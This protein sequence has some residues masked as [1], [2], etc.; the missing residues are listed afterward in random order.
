MKFVPKPVTDTVQELLDEQGNAEIKNPNYLLNPRYDSDIRGSDLKERRN[1]DADHS[2]NYTALMTRT[3][4]TEAMEPTRM[5]LRSS[6]FRPSPYYELV[7]G[8][9]NSVENLKRS[10]YIDKE[11]NKLSYK[12][13]G[14][15]QK[16]GSVKLYSTAKYGRPGQFVFPRR[17]RFNE[18]ADKEIRSQRSQSKDQLQTAQYLNSK[19]LDKANK[20]QSDNRSRL[21]SK[22]TMTV[23]QLRGFFSDKKTVNSKPT[24]SLSNTRIYKV[25]KSAGYVRRMVIDS[26]N[27]RYAASKHSSFLGGL[28][29]GQHVRNRFKVPVDV[30]KPITRTPLDEELF[31]D[32]GKRY[33]TIHQESPDAPLAEDPAEDDRLR[34]D[35]MLYDEREG[36]FFARMKAHG[37]DPLLA[38][39]SPEAMTVA[40]SAVDGLS[41][42]SA[43]PTAFYARK[44]SDYTKRLMR[45]QEIREHL[46]NKIK[47]LRRQVNANSKLIDMQLNSDKADKMALIDQRNCMQSGQNYTTHPQF[48][49]L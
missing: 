27:P 9:K 25:D 32:E 29:T 17:K 12:P 43:V 40:T 37:S 14:K 26:G 5:R 21:S 33:N 28:T 44:I 4:S 46:E 13:T 23:G 2:R 19:V 16:H 34:P 1:S 15:S 47:R 36:E 20:G 49:I 7:P 48:E 39:V 22:K 45:E 42:C 30:H 38:E 18:D 35:E 10:L 8:M 24:H 41:K 11:G 6:V 31:G 3:G